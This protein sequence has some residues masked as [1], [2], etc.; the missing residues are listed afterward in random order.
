M[1]FGEREIVFCK[2][3]I[4]PRNEKLDF[5]FSPTHPDVQAGAT[6]NKITMT[7]TFRIIESKDELLVEWVGQRIDITF[8]DM[9]GKS[10]PAMNSSSLKVGSVAGKSLELLMA[11]DQGGGDFY[12]VT[13]QFTLGGQP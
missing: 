11:C 1:R 7:G 10:G 6:Y 13:L 4:I 8:P 12:L 3:F 9:K 5:E 2:T